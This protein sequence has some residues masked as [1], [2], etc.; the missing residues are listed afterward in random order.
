MYLG[1]RDPLAVVA[2]GNVVQDG[3]HLDGFEQVLRVVARRAVATKR[4][5]HAGI[6]VLEHRRDTRAETQIRQWVVHGRGA[7][8]G[9]D[10]NV[11]IGQVDGVSARGL[12]VEVIQ[13]SKMRHCIARAKV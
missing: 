10:A 8:L 12:V 1:G 11:V 7:L 13:A 4:N 2:I 9:H 6:N 3:A 5:I